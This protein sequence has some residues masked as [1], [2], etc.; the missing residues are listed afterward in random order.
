MER[1]KISSHLECCPA[2][3]V[4]CCVEWNRWPNHSKAKFNNGFKTQ[5]LDPNDLDVAL[6]LRDQR[7]LS[8][9]WKAPKQMRCSLRNHLTRKYPAVPL[10]PYHGIVDEE[11]KRPDRWSESPESD[12]VSSSSHSSNRTPGLMTSVWSKLTSNTVKQPMTDEEKKLDHVINLMLKDLNSSDCIKSIKNG[13]MPPEPPVLPQCNL[14]LDLN[15]DVLAPYQQKP[16]LMYTFRCAQEFRRDQYHAHYKNVH[17]DIHG[18]LNGWMERRCPLWSYGCPFA[19]RRFDPEPKGSKIIYSS[20]SESFGVMFNQ[21]GIEANGN[22]GDM[23]N[24]LPVEVLQ[25]VCKYLDGFS[26]NNLSLTCIRMRSVTE[27]VLESQGIVVIQWVKS[28][29]TKG[30]KCSSWKPRRKSWLFT[31]SFDPITEWRF[32]ST[33]I[34]NHLQKCPFNEKITKSEPF[35]LPRDEKRWE[36]RCEGKKDI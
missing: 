10:K 26:L 34:L 16:K 22:H 8:Q 30:A 28:E 24:K 12:D 21:S 20:I 35:R 15:I 4:M 17:S 25:E 32:N 1:L 27:S 19:E 2:S 9:F 33:Q 7:M 5:S 6:A 11:P 23:I 14:S 29:A 13:F 18:S 31:N 3:V 36:R